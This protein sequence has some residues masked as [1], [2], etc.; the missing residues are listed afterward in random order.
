LIEKSFLSLTTRGFHHVAYNEWGQKDG[1]QTVICV[2]GLTRNSHDFDTLARA[3]EQDRR[4]A[5]PDIVG[6]GR[7]DWLADKQQY[8]F[9]TYCGDM[10]ALMARLG[11]E[12]FDWVGTSLGGFIGMFLAWQPNSPIRRLVINDAGAFVPKAVPQRMLEYVG[13]EQSFESL[14]QAE[15]YFRRIYKTFGPLTDAQWA[16]LTRHSVRRRSED[17]AY[18]LAYDPD[19]VAPMRNPQDLNLWPVWEEIR[20]PVLLLRGSESDVLTRDVVDRMLKRG[21]KTELVEFP[22]VGHAPALRDAGQIDVIKRWL[23]A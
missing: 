2:H 5:C 3:L 7:S 10:V 15:Q 9:A 13:I 19:I 21:P 6:R 20:C 16:E 17:R 22:G 18:T 14:A 11:N 8:N 23:A 1:A 4:V 12:T